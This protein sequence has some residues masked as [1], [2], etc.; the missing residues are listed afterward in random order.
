M[1][2][3]RTLYG[4]AIICALVSVSYANTPD[5]TPLGVTPKEAVVEKQQPL[6]PAPVQ[7]P[8]QPPVLE[9][10]PQETVPAIPQAATMPNLNEP[11]IAAPAEM[12]PTEKRTTKKAS[13]KNTQSQ[14]TMPEHDKRIVDSAIHGAIQRP[15]N[16]ANSQS[17][18]VYAYT[19]D[20]I[21]VVYGAPGRVIDVQLQPG[22]KLSGPVIAGDTTRWVVGSAMSTT[23]HIL[24]K[25]IQ[26]GLETNIIITTDRHVYH[27]LAR[28]LSRGFTPVVAWTYPHNEMA[29]FDI[30]NPE[31]E[32]GDAV[33]SADRGGIAAERLNFK[34]KI[35]PE[36]DYS[37]TPVR[38]FDDGRKTYIQM[39]TEMKNTE[40]PVLFVQGKEGLNLVNYRMKG[41]YYVVDRLFETAELRCGKDEKVLIK[42][43]KPWSFFG[44]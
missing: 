41:D 19:P 44:S 20:S 27:L 7:P 37:W 30:Y 4:I 29:Q 22:E 21:F 11:E 32:G 1:T 13:S 15:G 18:I 2:K 9:Q 28:S 14:I 38:V 26:P 16:S 39:G 17:K 8:V 40:A 35:K 31:N 36:E 3:N 23:T 24:I 43:D 42:R 25:P 33:Q 34:Y 5:S 6:A 12:P 10:P